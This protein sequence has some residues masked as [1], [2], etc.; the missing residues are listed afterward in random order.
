MKTIIE[1]TDGK[2]LGINIDDTQPTFI[3]EDWSFT[4]THTQHLGNGYVWYV[5]TSY[6]ILTKDIANGTN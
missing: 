1:T 4:P 5:T 3:F 2:Y 6:A